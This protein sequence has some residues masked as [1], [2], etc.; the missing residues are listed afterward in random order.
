MIAYGKGGVSPRY[1][2]LLKLLLFTP[3]RGV[4]NVVFVGNRA[5]MRGFAA[6]L[7]Y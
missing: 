4:I 2:R 6:S 5:L 3:C 7:L 1:H